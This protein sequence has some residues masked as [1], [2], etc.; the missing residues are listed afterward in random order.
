MTEESNSSDSQ[1]QQTG[2]DPATIL[3]RIID[4]NQAIQNSFQ[5]FLQSEAKTLDELAGL[6]REE[7]SQIE[8]FAPGVE[9]TQN[10]Q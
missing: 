6:M 10:S 2:T 8:L 7:L 9:P 3:C 5:R 4:V 1:Q